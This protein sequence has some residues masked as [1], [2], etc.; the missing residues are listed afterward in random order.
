MNA[1]RRLPDRRA[2][3][4]FALEVG[5]LRYT[6]LVSRFADGTIGEFFEQSQEQQ[7]RGYER[8]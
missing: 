1:R 6:R 8:A 7:R 4:T 3:E 5:G 2:R